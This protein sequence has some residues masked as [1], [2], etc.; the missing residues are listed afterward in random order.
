VRDPGPAAIAPAVSKTGQS[1]LSLREAA[2]M[3][4][5]S[6]S[7]ILRAIQSGRLAAP[8]TGDGSYAIER[9]ALLAVFPSKSGDG[10]VEPSGKAGSRA[11]KTAASRHGAET[12]PGPDVLAA[13]MAALEV[14][15][16]NLKALL[17]DVNPPRT[18]WRKI[19]G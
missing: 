8:K 6:K 11:V 19:A 3:A 15:I 18:W 12:T 14:E 4:G 1:G 13:R 9:A 2:A 16:K 10:A 5:A 7:T 17:G